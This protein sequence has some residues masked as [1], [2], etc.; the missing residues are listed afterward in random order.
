MEIYSAARVTSVGRCAVCLQIRQI[1]TDRSS[2]QTQVDCMSIL[3][4]SSVPR[5]FDSSVVGFLT[6]IS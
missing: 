1:R 6:K 2:G 4:A 5:R 3:D